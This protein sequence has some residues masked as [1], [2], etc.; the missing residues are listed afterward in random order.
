MVWVGVRALNNLLPTRYICFMVMQ[1]EHL[2]IT[3][4]ITSHNFLLPA[5]T[6]KLPTW[7]TPVKKDK[8]GPQS[9]RDTSPW[10][11]TPLH[12]G[13]AIGSVTEPT[14]HESCPAVPLLIHWYPLVHC[15]HLHCHPGSVFN[16]TVQF[17]LDKLFQKYIYPNYNELA[18]SLKINIKHLESKWHSHFPLCFHSFEKGVQHFIRNVLLLET[19]AIQTASQMCIPE[20]QPHYVFT[21]CHTTFQWVS[22]GKP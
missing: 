20:T 22:A 8:P 7:R 21:F 3:S 9:R 5:T 2:T 15:H 16:V 6:T 18:F 10:L 14:P 12:S 11:Y 4:T 19:C 17:P 13:A 1:V